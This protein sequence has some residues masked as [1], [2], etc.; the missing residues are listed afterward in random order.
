MVGGAAV[1]A[2]ESSEAVLGASV[3]GCAK[4]PVQV[5]TAIAKPTALTLIKRFDS[6]IY[7]PFSKK[8]RPVP[9]DAAPTTRFDERDRTGEI[10]ESQGCERCKNLTD[11][12]RRHGASAD[13]SMM[14]DL[15]SAGRCGL[16]AR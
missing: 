16:A 11:Y 7:A 9:P 6:L 10:P 12:P 5:N 1:V 15:G 8:K 3:C 14:R 4:A 13:K 2:G